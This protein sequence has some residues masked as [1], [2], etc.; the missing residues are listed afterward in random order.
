MGASLADDVLGILSH[1]PDVSEKTNPVVGEH[2]LDA[3]YGLMLGPVG[4]SHACQRRARGQHR[5]RQ[6]LPALASHRTCETRDTSAQNAPASSMPCRLTR[7]HP[8][9]V[10][11]ALSV[12]R[13]RYHLERDAQGILITTRNAIHRHFNCCLVYSPGKYLGTNGTGRLVRTL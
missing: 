12:W 8:S 13:S 11:S 3:G 9:A 2:S 1:I 10:I 4:T 6:S 7:N 5:G